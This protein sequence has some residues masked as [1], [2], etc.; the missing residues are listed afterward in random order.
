MS[1]NNNFFN[2]P[3]GVPADFMDQF[4]NIDK[5]SWGDNKRG[6]S[7]KN[8][9]E[10]SE[11]MIQLNQ[12]GSG[13]IDLQQSIDEDQQMIVRVKNGVLLE[14]II[15]PI[16]EEIIRMVKSNVNKASIKPSSNTA[17]QKDTIKP[18]EMRLFVKGNSVYTESLEPDLS[19]I[20]TITRENGEIIFPSGVNYN[21][22]NKV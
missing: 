21:L 4:K 5:V 22:L 13:L 12:K 7:S 9:V 20:I 1:K 6:S 2:N 15:I 8:S 19:D 18:I 16:R 11:V 17:F 3:P 14:S 10:N